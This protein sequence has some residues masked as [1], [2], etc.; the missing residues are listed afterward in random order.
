[1]IIKRVLKFPFTVFPVPNYAEKCLIKSCKS[2]NK[3]QLGER[4]NATIE[5]YFLASNGCVDDQQKSQIAEL[6]NLMHYQ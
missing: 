3:L 5:N 6:I 4:K 1:L 2:V